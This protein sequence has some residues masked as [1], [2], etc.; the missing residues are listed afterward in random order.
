MI[1]TLLR[2]AVFAT[3]TVGAVWALHLLVWNVLPRLL[4]TREGPGPR[5]TLLTIWSATVALCMIA[6]IRFIPQGADLQLGAMV[7]LFPVAAVLWLG[8]Q[9]RPSYGFARLP[10]TTSLDRDYNAA[11]AIG[12]ALGVVVALFVRL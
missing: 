6:T 4:P 1:Q 5:T 9:S 3:A 2:D 11:S 12:L 10:G 7:V 8:R